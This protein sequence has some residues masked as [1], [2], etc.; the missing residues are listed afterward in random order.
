MALIPEK[1]LAELPR[2]YATENVQDK[3]A[4]I[5]I[6]QPWGRGT[7]YL[8]E[9]QTDEGADGDWLF[10]CYCVSPLGPDCDEY[11]YITLG[12]MTS[13]SGPGGLTLERDLWWKPTPMSKIL[14]GETT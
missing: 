12:Q 9:G 3:I 6:F 13:I 10:F 14:S 5:K 4:P 11:G 7:W 8:L 1:M 2:L